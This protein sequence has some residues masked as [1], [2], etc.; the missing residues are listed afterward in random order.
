VL[1]L[2]S[3][4]YLTLPAQSVDATPLVCCDIQPGR[5]LVRHAV[6]RLVMEPLSGSP[7]AA[8]C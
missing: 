8:A 1:P 7:V 4:D 2:I 6:R 3:P 5:V